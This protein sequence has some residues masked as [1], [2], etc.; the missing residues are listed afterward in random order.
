MGDGAA[1]ALDAGADL[2]HFD[3]MDGHFVPNLTM[4]PDMCRALRRELPACCFDVHLMV[5]EPKRFLAPFVESGASHLTFHVE[6]VPEPAPLIKAIHAAGLTAG[7][8]L[9]PPT[10]VER[11]RPWIEA[12]DVVLV[13]SVNPGFA[14]QRFLSEVLD[15]V[16]RIAPLLRADQRLEIDGGVNAQTAAAAREAGCDC[17]VAA[18]AIFGADDYAAAISGLR[19]RPVLTR[20]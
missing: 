18:S 3:V 17:L 16:R 20:E 8:A 2:L 9:N 10:G 7:I 6:A 15:K 1:A 13:M 4:G 11:V 14:G 12:S 19:G 5:R